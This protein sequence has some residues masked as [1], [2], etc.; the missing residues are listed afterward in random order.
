VVLDE[1]DNLS[2]IGPDGKRVWIAREK[3]GGTTTY[4]DT[5]KKRD[6]AYKSGEMPGYR[7][8]IPARI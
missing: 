1:L 5:R 7:T 8:Y 6:S 4:Y 3:F 2:L